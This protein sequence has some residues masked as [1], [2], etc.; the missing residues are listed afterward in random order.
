MFGNRFVCVSVWW[1]DWPFK[2]GQVN[3]IRPLLVSQ[4]VCYQATLSRHF[5]KY[6]QS[7]SNCAK[8]LAVVLLL[9]LTGATHHFLYDLNNIEEE[10]IFLWT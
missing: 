2:M 8:S 5:T 7:Q 6:F 3:N 4:S 10:I 1:L 9:A